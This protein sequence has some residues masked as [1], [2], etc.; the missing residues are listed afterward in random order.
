[1]MIGLTLSWGLNGV[2]AK[3]S[4]TGYSPVFL[5]V[6][7]SALGGALVFAW[8][9]W[10]GI[11]L[12]DRDG[13]LWAGIAGG[14][15][16]CCWNSLL[17]FVG[18]DFTSVAR[19]TLLVNTMPFW[20]LVGGHLFLGERVTVRKFAGLLLAF[21]GLVLIF[22]DKLSQPGPEAMIGDLMS[23]GAGLG[24][25]RYQRRHQTNQA[26]QRRCGKAAALSTCRR[27]R[28]RGAGLAVRA[29]RRSATPTRWR[30]G[31]CSSRR[32]MSSLSPM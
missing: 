21:G 22:S 7:R 31:R 24:L 29:D 11:R 8:C 6:V 18:L 26:C 17:I 28:R 14:C 19:S 20:M 27:C 10:R 9:W 2:A 32:C 3:L 30:P 1:M 5:T 15:A 23:L 25:G 13:T 16:V 4:N 12:F